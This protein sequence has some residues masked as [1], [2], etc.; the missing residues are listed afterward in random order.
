[1][2]FTI[3]Q[4]SII[5]LA[6]R[7]GTTDQFSTVAL[8][9]VDSIAKPTISSVNLEVTTKAVPVSSPKPT[10]AP[11]TFPSQVQVSS[12]TNSPKQIPGPAE[13]P[14]SSQARKSTKQPVSAGNEQS[15]NDGRLEDGRPSPKPDNPL[16]SGT[17]ATKLPSQATKPADDSPG[18]PGGQNAL[19]VL[20]EAQS[21]A[22][23][24]DPVTPTPSNPTHDGP[25]TS[26]PVSATSGSELF[27]ISL[28]D[29]GS[30][31]IRMAESSLVIS[32]YGL[33][34]VAAPG[35]EVTI[36]THVFSAASQD[37]AVIV[38]SIATYAVPSSADSSAALI[39]T[40]DGRVVSANHQ[41]DQVFILDGTKTLTAEAGESLTVG[42]QT[43]S[44]NDGAFELVVGTTTLVIPI[45]ADAAPIDDVAVTTPSTNGKKRIASVVANGDSA[46]LQQGSNIRL[47][48]GAG[49]QTVVY[50]ATVSVAQSGGALVLINA[51]ETVSLSL[52][53]VSAT[54]EMPENG[55]ARSSGVEK[56]TSPSTGSDYPGQT[57]ESSGASSSSTSPPEAESN[58]GS[59]GRGSIDSVRGLSLFVSVAACVGLL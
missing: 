20:S 33:S 31:T 57:A 28:A 50:G 4:V 41:D 48:L 29:G 36:G 43:I 49:E 35:R 11:V 18:S 2:A 5:W 10:L 9:P 44:V 26:D 7:C 13:E 25:S 15:Q 21:S 12:E 23:A 30:A 58:S 53:T 17:D 45:K 3:L 59:V 24:A 14:S 8:T 52:L 37:D 38:D 40:A 1:M 16:T 46:V 51:S 47:T 6:K 54:A 19:S 56:I 55:H 27:T 42:S 32:Q 22:E 39:F 34:A